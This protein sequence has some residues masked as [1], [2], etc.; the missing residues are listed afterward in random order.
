MIALSGSLSIA[1]FTGGLAT[2]PPEDY[3]RVA[4]LV[5]DP[6]SL[7]SDLEFILEAYFPSFIFDGTSADD[8]YVFSDI[9]NLSQLSG[10]DI[11]IAYS[12]S[13]TQSQN[14]PQSI[15]EQFASA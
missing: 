8:V 4:V 11:V 14:V 1:D 6:A 3:R 9:T 10:Y 2:L 5:A 12:S 15:L 7:N 13:M